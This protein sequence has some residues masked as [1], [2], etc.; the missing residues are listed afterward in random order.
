MSSEHPDLRWVWALGFFEGLGQGHVASELTILWG[1][2][3][4]V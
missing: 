4:R 2:G 1:L 3:F